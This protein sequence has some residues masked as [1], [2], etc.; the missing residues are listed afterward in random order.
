MVGEREEA[1]IAPERG[2]ERRTK[3]GSLVEGNGGGMVVLLQ[4]KIDDDSDGT[5]KTWRPEE[6]MKARGGSCGGGNG[7]VRWS[8]PEV[9]V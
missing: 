9:T 4:W 6:R 1:R 8:S 3:A 7:G 5:V 2:E